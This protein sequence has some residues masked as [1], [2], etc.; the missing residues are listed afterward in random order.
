MGVRAFVEVDA[1]T[2]DDLH[3]LLQPLITGLQAHTSLDKTDH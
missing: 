2:H 1:P 3:A